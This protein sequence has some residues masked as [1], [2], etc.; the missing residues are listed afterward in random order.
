MPRK[1]QPPRLWLRPRNDGRKPVWIIRDGSRQRST[2]AL[3]HEL[4]KA[5]KALADYLGENHHHTRNSRTDAALVLDALIYYSDAKA[6]IA[7]PERIGYAIDA[8]GHWWSDR[9][10]SDVTGANCRAYADDRGASDGTVRRELGVLRAALNLYHAEGYIQTVPRVTLPAAPMPRERWLTKAEAEALIVAAE[11]LERAPHLPLFI[12]L[13]LH[14]GTRHAAALALQWQPNTVGGW[15]DLDQRMLYRAPVGDRRRA[16]RKPPSILSDAILP[17][18]EEARE[19]T[20]QYVIEY[21]GGAVQS[22]KK[23]FAKACQIAGLADVIPHTLRHTC[24]TWLA[25][26]GVPIWKAA[27]YIGVSDA[28]FD[29]TYGHYHPDFM[30][31]VIDSIDRR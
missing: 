8:L 4:E 15:I 12:R 19:K 29:R 22:V 24:G 11:T 18:L 7:A 13:G 9:P 17:Y 6:K 23:S 25:L 20:R 31:E 21:Q 5:E 2:G 3:E 26:D 30:G 1:R 10:I 28:E 16:K 27:R 14:T